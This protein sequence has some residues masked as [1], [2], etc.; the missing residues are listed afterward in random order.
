M[1]SDTATCCTFI[2]MFVTKSVIPWYSHPDSHTCLHSF[3][4]CLFVNTTFVGSAHKP[5]FSSLYSCLSAHSY[6]PFSFDRMTNN[7]LSSS[8]LVSLRFMFLL[9]GDII[10]SYRG[11]LVPDP[12]TAGTQTCQV[13]CTFTSRLSLHRELPP[14]SFGA[15][16]SHNW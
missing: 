11:H 6:Q 13:L 3:F 14:A 7:F 2:N 1:F 8:G 4:T 12:P 10:L 5:V 9:S 15:R 16:T